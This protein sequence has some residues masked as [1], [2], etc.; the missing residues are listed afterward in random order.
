MFYLPERAR[1]FENAGKRSRHA[2]E[3]Y[4]KLLIPYAFPQLTL[5]DGPSAGMEYPM[6]INSNQGAADHETFHQWLPMMVGT[7]ETRYGWMDEGFNQYSNILSAADAGGAGSF[8]L[9]MLPSPRFS[10]R[11]EERPEGLP[12]PFQRPSALGE[13]FLQRLAGR[14]DQRVGGGDAGLGTGLIEELPGHRAGL[15]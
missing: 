7:N 5:Q 9:A 2:L 11:D 3:F 4:S 6:V 12:G 13:R 1:F 8:F 14:H 10:A 15:A